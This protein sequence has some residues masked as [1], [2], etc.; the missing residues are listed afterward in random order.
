MKRAL[1]LGASALVVAALAQAPAGASNHIITLTATLSGSQEN[2]GVTTGAFGHATVTVDRNTGAITVNGAIYNLGSGLTAGHIHVGGP[3]VNGPVV[4]NFP[5]TPNVS[6]DF[7][8][9][10]NLNASEFVLREQQGIRSPEDLIQAITAG[11]TYVN[12]HTAVNPGGEVRGQLCPVGGAPANT[13]TG[14]A[15]CA[16]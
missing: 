1:V 9:S 11:T 8:F 12:F 3:G 2:P 5:V 10:F 13:V 16:S 4:L 14:V 7:G 6:N 15:I